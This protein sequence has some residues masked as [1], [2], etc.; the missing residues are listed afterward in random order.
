MG[1][2]DIS[3]LTAT[4]RLSTP[5]IFASSGEVVAERAGILNIG[6]EG[7]MLA[8][9]FFGFLFTHLTNS[10]LVGVLAG[11]VAGM[12]FAAIAAALAI[13]A[14]ANQ[15]VVGIG[16]N[17]LAFGITAMLFRRVF[18]SSDQVLLDRP[19]PWV[20]P[21]LSDIPFVGE[22]LFNHPG[23]VY[24]AFLSVPAVSILLYQTNFGMAVRASGETPSAADTAGVNITLVRWSANLLAGAMAGAGGSFLSIELGVFIEGLTAGRGFL[25]LAAV[26]FGRWHPLGAL[27]ASLLFGAADALQLRLQALPSIPFEV[28]LLIG[29]VGTAYLVWYR[30]RMRESSRTIIVAGVGVIAMAAF[31][32]AL[33][34]PDI[35]LPPQLWR[36]LPLVLTLVVLI[37]AMGKARM[38]S[39]LAIPYSR[40]TL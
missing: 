34:V 12:L 5:L 27:S 7:M 37:G 39:A 28:W 9:A 26:I 8:G 38:P 21:W 11:V 15:I 31:G 33:W 13:H 29:L 16:I 30:V 2:F 6:L 36:T 22:L 17:V 24:V 25:A 10:F 18:S 14:R 35:S 23:W 1:V 3:W 4:I 19:S 32:L 40:E 20:I